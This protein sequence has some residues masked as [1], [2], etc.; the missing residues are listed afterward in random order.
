MSFAVAADMIWTSDNAHR[1]L[2]PTPT[3]LGILTDLL[4]GKRMAL[5]T[6]F[7]GIWQR[8]EQ[9]VR[10]RWVIELPAAIQLIGMSLR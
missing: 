5:L 4:D 7:N 8:G 6:W 10:S 9:K 3:Q 1:S 2:L